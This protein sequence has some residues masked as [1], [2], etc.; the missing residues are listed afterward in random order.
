MEAY[1]SY[2]RSPA[3]PAIVFC[4]AILLLVY[5]R[6]IGRTPT[7]T[8]LDVVW[9]NLGGTIVG[10]CAP[11]IVLSVIPGILFTLWYHGW[12]ACAKPSGDTDTDNNPY[13]EIIETGSGSCTS[14]PQC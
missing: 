12:N 8:V 7:L 2:L 5:Q 9:C 10:L 11:I 1:D 4:T 3:C 6:I 13:E 14:N